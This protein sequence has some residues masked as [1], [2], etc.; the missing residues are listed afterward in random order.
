MCFSPTLWNRH[1]CNEINSKLVPG[2]ISTCWSWIWGQKPSKFSPR[3]RNFYFLF[4]IIPINFLLFLFLGHFWIKIWD[5][6]RI[7]L[8]NYWRALRATTAA[9]LWGSDR[10]ERTFGFWAADAS[11]HRGWPLSTFFSTS[12]RRSK[13]LG[14]MLRKSILGRPGG[15]GGGPGDVLGGSWSPLTPPAA[16]EQPDGNQPSPSFSDFKP[17]LTS[18]HFSSLFLLRLGSLLG[19]LLEPFWRLSWL[20]FGPSCL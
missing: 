15:S 2:E 4:P 7:Q 8:A 1:Q 10:C 6:R 11:D 3:P 5:S 18:L 19:S 14:Q 13:F 20:K 12:F 16:S 17:L 9:T